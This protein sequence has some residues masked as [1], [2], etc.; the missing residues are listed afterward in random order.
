MIKV[1]W[2]FHHFVA[3]HSL[4]NV[5]DNKYGDYYVTEVHL[6]SQPIQYV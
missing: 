3:I 4:I 5:Q 1:F 6:T 2:P